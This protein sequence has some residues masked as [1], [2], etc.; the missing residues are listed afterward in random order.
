MVFSEVRHLI[1]QKIE[2]YKRE[3]EREENRALKCQLPTQGPSAK[4]RERRMA[5]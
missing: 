4:G 3:R 5:G 1:K 2:L